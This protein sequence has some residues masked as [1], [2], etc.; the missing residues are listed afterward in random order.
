MEARRGAAL[1]GTRVQDTCVR[2]HHL[3]VCVGLMWDTYPCEA[4]VCGMMWEP[5]TSPCEARM[6]RGRDAPL[7][8]CWMTRHLA[9]AIRGPCLREPRGG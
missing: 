7:R 1:R 9:L 3:S 8:V 6:K 5:R 4:C 2:H